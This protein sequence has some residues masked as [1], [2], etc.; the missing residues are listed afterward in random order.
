MNSRETTHFES[1][2]LRHT[3]ITNI[4]NI[5]NIHRGVEAVG[6]VCRFNVMADSTGPLF[7][8]HTKASIHE[9]QARLHPMAGFVNIS[10]LTNSV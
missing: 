2:I 7:N 6:A 10:S 8:K 3:D 4:T 1:R 9:T 5:D